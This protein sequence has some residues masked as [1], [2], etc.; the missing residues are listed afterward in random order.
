[1]T[2]V[3]ARFSNVHKRFG[4]VDALSGLELSI[5]RGSVV[6]L[7]GRNGAGKSTALRCLVG[8]ERPDSGQLSVVGHEPLTLDVPMRQRIGYLSED[9]VPFPFATADK[10]IRFCAPLYPHWSGALEQ[11]ILSR[12]QIDPR[13]K[14]RD[15][16]L[17]QRRAVGLLL[18]VC[19][20]PELLILDEPA[21]N[22]DALVRREFL[23]I[24]LGLVGDD[25]AR[26]T[27]IFS[28]HILSDVERIA[29][30]VAILHHGRLLIERPLDELKEQVRR[31][32]LMFAGA[33]PERLELS[34]LLSLR[35]AGHEMRATVIG[36]D[37]DAIEDLAVDLH[38]RVEVQQLGL[39]ELFIDLVDDGDSAAAA[40]A[41]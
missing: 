2:E 25:D 15:L 36:Y 33:P 4:D 30:R 18:A 21:A 40:A 10:L 12:F 9:G 11:Q 14:L 38:A 20:Q 41:I 27:V 23:D 39:E 28:S 6:A 31:L 1:M 3:S 35:R 19:P 32:R 24:V 26:R 13:R 5:P 16:S 7:L 37:D 8:L 22:L 17:G 29:D 34:G